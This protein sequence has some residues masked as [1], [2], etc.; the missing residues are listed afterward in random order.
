MSFGGKN[1]PS[2]LSLF[3]DLKLSQSLCRAKNVHQAGTGQAGEHRC[4]GREDGLW[5]QLHP[6]RC[7]LATWELVTT[8]A[9]SLSKQELGTTSDL[10]RR[11]LVE[12]VSVSI[13]SLLRQKKHLWK[14]GQ[15]VSKS[16]EIVPKGSRR[17][18]QK[19]LRISNSCTP[20]PCAR[21]CPPLS[22]ISPVLALESAI[23]YRGCQQHFC[24]L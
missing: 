12:V 17:E 6:P 5:E 22:N 10:K 7:P 1:L 4:D 13:I 9:W 16:V 20:E 3:W 8:A 11:Q 19:W 14:A 2:A 24:C 21:Q 18:S 15:F 23:T